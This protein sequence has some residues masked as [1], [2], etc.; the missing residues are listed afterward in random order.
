M[1]VSALET[2][3]GDS[4]ESTENNAKEDVRPDYGQRRLD[5]IVQSHETRWLEL[6]YESRSLL[7]AG[8]AR[9]DPGSRETRAA[10][11]QSPMI[12]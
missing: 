12:A 5:A 7:L 2:G 9:M 11:R 1:S 4:V 8:H 6:A 10:L 3:R